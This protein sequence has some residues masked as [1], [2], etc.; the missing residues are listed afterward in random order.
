[1]AEVTRE[2]YVFSIEG[3][4]LRV[5]VDA[6]EVDRAALS[7][8]SCEEGRYYIILGALLMNANFSAEEWDVL[9]GRVLAAVEEVLPEAVEQVEEALPEVVEPV[10]EEEPVLATPVAPTGFKRRRTF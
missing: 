6:V 3:E 1:M 2:P 8:A 7:Q 4:Y 5:F 9:N 10:A